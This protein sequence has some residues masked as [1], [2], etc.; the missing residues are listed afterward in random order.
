MTHWTT[1]ARAI[2]MLFPLLLA[3]SAGI[4]A[5]PPKDL[6]VPPLHIPGLYQGTPTPNSA[7][8]LVGRLKCQK[9]VQ[10]NAWFASGCIP[11]QGSYPVAG[12]PRSCG[13]CRSQQKPFVY[14]CQPHPDSSCA[15]RSGGI[16]TCGPWMTGVCS[17][18]GACIASP[19]IHTGCIRPDCYS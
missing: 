1:H 8:P 19:V 11:G 7:G 14:I 15:D 18:N 16:V 9:M 17:N 4:G 13:Y 10:C 12:A 6:S 3:L 5:T 2:E